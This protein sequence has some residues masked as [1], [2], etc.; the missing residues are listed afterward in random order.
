[1]GGGG[2]G[3]VR[4]SLGEARKGGNNSPFLCFY[5]PLLCN[6]ESSPFILQE[7]VLYLFLLSLRLLAANARKRERNN[8]KIAKRK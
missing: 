3:G 4:L 2:G 8:A 1:M 5:F 7:F 6:L